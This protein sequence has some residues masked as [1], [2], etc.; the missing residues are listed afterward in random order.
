MRFWHPLVL[1]TC[2]Q[3]LVSPVGRLVPL[4]GWATALGSH[5]G[6]RVGDPSS[7]L[8]R[9]GS[10]GLGCTRGRAC[11]SRRKSRGFFSGCRL[12]TRR[13]SKSRPSRLGPGR[14]LPAEMNGGCTPSRE[15]K[16]G[17]CE[18]GMV[19]TA[20]AAGRNG[21]AGPRRRVTRVQAPSRR[22]G[23]R[24]FGVALRLLIARNFR[25]P[26]GT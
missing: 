26:P 14:R 9:G 2:G 19:Y 23:K 3:L 6:C 13:W 24:L 18:V 7:S 1:T 22:S 15:K 16:N 11:R 4:S 25:G 8:W 17:L 20:P 10:Q 12:R 5:P 21:L